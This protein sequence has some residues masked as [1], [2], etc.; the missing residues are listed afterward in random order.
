MNSIK[1]NFE[2]PV[3]Y[4]SNINAVSKTEKAE[5]LANTFVKSHSS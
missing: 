4:S 1:C 3:R 2:V 5:L